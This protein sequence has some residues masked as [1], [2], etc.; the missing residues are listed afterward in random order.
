MFDD[1]DDIFLWFFSFHADLAKCGTFV[2]WVPLIALAVVVG[3]IKP[4]IGYLLVDDVQFL[5]NSRIGYICLVLELYYQF[6]KA[7]S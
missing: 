6:F 4:I 2:I 7:D 5:V 3:L 1:L